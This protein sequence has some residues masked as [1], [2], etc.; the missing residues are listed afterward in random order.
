M[1]KKIDRRILKSKNAI[2]ESFLQLLEKKGFDSLSV[3]EI[4]E[5]A[6]IGRKTFYL[7]YDDLYDLL[8]HVLDKEMMELSTA[9]GSKEV[10][11]FTDGAISW[12]RYFERKRSFF[13]TLFVSNRTV[14]FRDRL[15]KLIMDDLERKAINFGVD[16]DEIDSYFFGMAILGIVESMML[17][18]IKADTEQI[19]CRIGSLLE[20]NLLKQ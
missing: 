13:T 4:A 5:Y 2:E 17:N 15:L 11:D 14:V 16:L 12:F 18:H 20:K 10:K 9:C 1:D 6:N 19:A 7:H 8:N 3:K